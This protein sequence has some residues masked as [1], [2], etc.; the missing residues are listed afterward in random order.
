MTAAQLERG[1]I[2][3]ASWRDNT[4][5]KPPKSSKPEKKLSEPKSKK[6]R[7]NWVTDVADAVSKENIKRMSS[8]WPQESLL[9]DSFAWRPPGSGQSELAVSSIVIITGLTSNSEHN[10]KNGQLCERASDGS[11][12]VVIND[13][14]GGRKPLGVSAEH[15]RLR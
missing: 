8:G 15:L 13:D 6:F 1:K 5:S 11:W 2:A 10:D 4:K 14:C 7:K 9:V 12:I 3:F